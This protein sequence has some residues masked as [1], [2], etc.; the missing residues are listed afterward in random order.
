MVLKQDEGLRRVSGERR[1]EEGG[2][3]RLHHH[4]VDVAPGTAC[5]LSPAPPPS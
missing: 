1:E 3:G 2:K 4:H 5:L